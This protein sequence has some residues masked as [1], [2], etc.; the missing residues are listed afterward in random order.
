MVDLAVLASVIFVFGLVSRRLEG[1]ILTA[2]LVFVAAGVILGPAGFGLV[3]FELDDHTRE[4][5]NGRTGDPRGLC[6]D[7][8]PE[9]W[10]RPNEISRWKEPG[11]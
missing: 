9:R 8:V 4:A 11:T 3:E 5:K 7:Q 1:T 2:P 6:A 10:V